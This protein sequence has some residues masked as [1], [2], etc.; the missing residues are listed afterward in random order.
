MALSSAR[1]L[2]TV[3]ILTRFVGILHAQE[4]AEPSKFTVQ[5][6]TVDQ[7]VKLE[8]VDWGGTGRPLVL[9]AAL[10][11]DAHEFDN[12]A[13]KLADKY[14]VY[15]ITRRGFGASSSPALGYTAD[16][17]GDDVAA[18]IDSL[19]LNRPVLVGHS[20]AGEELSSVGTRHPEKV[21][22]LVYL[23][24]AYSY[25]YYNRAAGDLT[26][27][28][29]EFQE[30]L[31]LLLP[32]KGGVDRRHLVDDL[33]QS[34]PQLQ[35][36]LAV[37]QDKMRAYPEPPKS[38]TQPAEPDAPVPIKG[39]LTGEQKYTDIRVPI[40]AIYAVPHAFKGMF[41]NDPVAR[42]K[43]E[44]DDLESVGAQADALQRGIPTARIVRI[45]H[46]THYIMGSNEAEVLREMNAFID[47]LP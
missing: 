13:P 28:T 18:V 45:P 43:A 6:V 15:G 32:G 33:L 26:I 24:A 47:R 31:Q 23:E 2:L 12:F 29:I 10:G 20:I 36:D 22:G 42:A 41:E 25:A 19:K 34:L 37:M 5:Y 9:L 39:I 16:R 44:A 3:S 8:V 27:D 38:A 1:M 17:L 40:L 46:A 11:A 35:R 7:D 4:K 21:A 30:K 14:H